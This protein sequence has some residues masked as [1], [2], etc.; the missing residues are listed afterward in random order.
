M[1]LSIVMIALLI[2]S[3]AEIFFQ[4]I[5]K[6]ITFI[7]GIF[8]K[9]FQIGEKGRPFIKLPSAIL[10]LI[11]SIYFIMNLAFKVATLLGF[12]LDESMTDIF[13]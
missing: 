8:N 11:A 12:S 10:F 6:F 3:G 9:G 2:L 1:G 13:K 5:S 7:M 4:V